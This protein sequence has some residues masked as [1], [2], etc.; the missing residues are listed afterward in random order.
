MQNLKK[1]KG[2]IDFVFPK[3]SIQFSGIGYPCRLG[4][5]VKPLLDLA[6]IFFR[7]RQDVPFVV[8]GHTIE[9]KMIT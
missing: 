8:L 7:G 9:M 3:V 2:T 6:K 5:L 4:K 1:I